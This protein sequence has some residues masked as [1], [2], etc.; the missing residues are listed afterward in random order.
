MLTSAWARRT[1]RQHGQLV[2]HLADAVPQVGDRARIRACRVVQL[3][4]QARGDGAEGKQLLP[5]V[6]DLAGPHPAHLVPFEQVHGHGELGLHEPTE[7]VGVEDEELRRLGHPDR[8]LILVFLVGIECRP[9]AAAPRAEVRLVSM[10][11]P[12]E[13]FDIT[14]SPSIRT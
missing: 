12:P 3:M 1:V 5:L 9:G 13:R 11:S 8:G 7:G 6:D 2:P 14:S 10:S 4:S